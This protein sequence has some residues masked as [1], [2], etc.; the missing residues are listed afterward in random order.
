MHPSSPSCTQWILIDAEH[1]Q[2]GDTEMHQMIPAIIGAGVSPIVRVP[3]PENF[4]VKRA[5][6]AGAHGLMF[7]MI[8]TK[9][10]CCQCAHPGAFHH[11]HRLLTCPAVCA[12]YHF[13]QEQA[14]AVVRMSKFPPMGVRGC[15]SPFAPAYFGQTMPQYLDTANDATIIMVQI[16]T[17]LGLKNVHEIA[18]VP[19]I[20][21]SEGSTARNAL[22]AP[23]CLDVPC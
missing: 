11:L 3:A 17:P 6:D 13:L 14:E 8:E 12:C 5:L 20:G 10:R 21:E 7:P 23:S 15:G 4:L 22:T 9:V 1:G 19:G 16:E 2:I 18:S